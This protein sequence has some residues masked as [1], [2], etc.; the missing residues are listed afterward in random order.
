MNDE[1]Y[2][3]RAV[4]HFG[5]YCLLFAP[6]AL[7]APRAVARPETSHVEVTQQTK[8][9]ERDGQRDF[10][11]QIGTWTSRLSRL[12]HPLSHSTDWEEYEGTS[13][14]RRVWNGRASLVELEADGRAGHIE[15]LSLHLYHPQSRQW[16]LHYATSSS[17]LLDP[18]VVGQFKDGRGEFF[19]QDVFDGKAIYV[20]HVWSDITP[21][22]CRFEQSFSS[23]GGK[24]W[25]V[26]WKKVFTRVDR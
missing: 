11:F 25:E 5:V 24:T 14:V 10:D 20:R 6:V 18:P 9:D 7:T 2:V 3:M 15:V 21:D 4:R 12:M 1:A 8:P 23:D 17:G 19:G 26:N 22:A 16:S 13:V